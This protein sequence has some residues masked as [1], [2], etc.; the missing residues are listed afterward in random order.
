M[1]KIAL[2][3]L[4]AA[5]AAASLGGAACSKGQTGGG[6]NTMSGYVRAEGETDNGYDCGC[7][8]DCKCKGECDDDCDC[9][10]NC[11][12]GK[13]AQKGGNKEERK[14]GGRN[15]RGEEAGGTG[16][17]EFDGE[18]M[19]G[20]FDKKRDGFGFFAP[21][22][23]MFGRDPMPVPPP[24]RT[25]GIEGNENPITGQEGENTDG[26]SRSSADGSVKAP[27][28][29]KGGGRK[30]DDGGRKRLKKPDSKERTAG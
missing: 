21:D 3:L 28:N 19:D 14:R 15:M 30:R 23:G 20:K 26:K 18:K 27:E 1:K 4:T 22:N 5:L 10:E 11:D 29:G 16:G 13:E 7:G 12:C 2:I 8:D 9:K 24:P 6:N 25:E 17:F